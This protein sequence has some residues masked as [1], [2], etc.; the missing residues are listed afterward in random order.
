MSEELRSID[1]QEDKRKEVQAKI[2][3]KSQNLIRIHVKN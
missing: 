1:L 3:K 2:I